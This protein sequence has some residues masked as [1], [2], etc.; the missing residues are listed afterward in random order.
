MTKAAKTDETTTS[1]IRGHCEWLG[2][3]AVKGWALDSGVPDVP[4]TVDLRDTEGFSI[5]LVAEEFRPDLKRAGI[6]TGFHGFA[7]TLPDDFWVGADRKVLWIA[8]YES[9]TLLNGSPLRF[10]YPRFA[11]QVGGPSGGHLRGWCANLSNPDEPVQVQFSESGRVLGYAVADED[12]TGSRGERF[13]AG[14]CG[15][16]FALPGEYLDGSTR[17]LELTDAASGTPLPDSPVLVRFPR[18]RE[19]LREQERYR[20]RVLRAAALH[21]ASPQGNP[22]SSKVACRAASMLASDNPSE[23]NNRRHRVCNVT[24]SESVVVS[25]IVPFRTDSELALQSALSAIATAGAVSTEIILVSAGSSRSRIGALSGVKCVSLKTFCGWPAAWNAG[26]RHACGRIILFLQPGALLEP[27]AL[28]EMVNVFDMRSECAAVAPAIFDA[29]RKLWSSGGQIGRGGEL[30]YE[31]HYSDPDLSRTR[32]LRRTDFCPSPAFAVSREAYAELGGFDES[33]SPDYASAELAAF[34]HH[35]RKEVFVQPSAIVRLE[36]S[37]DFLVHPT[38]AKI[39]DRSGR[40]HLARSDRVHY[41]P[42]P[43]QESVALVIDFQI[44]RW[45]QSAGAKCTANEIS[46]FMA[47]GYRVVLLAPPFRGDAPYR[48]MF[49]REGVECVVARGS[50]AD[51]IANLPE[52]SVVFAIRYYCLNP[53][54]QSIRNRWPN[55]RVLFNPADLHFLREQRKQ[56]LSASNDS[57]VEDIDRITAAELR[58]IEFADVTLPYSSVEVGEIHARIPAARTGIC[59][60]VAEDVSDVPGLKDRAGLVFLG[61]FDHAPN[62]D[63]VQYFVDDI[64]P[65]VLSVLP[66]TRFY[67]FGS[68]MPDEIRDLQSDHVVPMGYVESLRDVYDS[69]RVFV[70]P[71]RFGAGVKGKVIESMSYGCPGVMTDLSIEGIAV[72]PGTHCLVANDPLSFAEQTIELLENDELWMRLHAEVR[73]RVTEV[74]GFSTAVDAF[75]DILTD[76]GLPARRQSMTRRLPMLPIEQILNDQ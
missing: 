5:Q 38:Q 2:G 27:L 41:P 4:V 22:E 17:Y 11:G 61:G 30:T 58:A 68:R 20:E 72:E 60:W 53:Y 67:I 33:L 71:L 44:P 40:R 48:A 70:S 51:V 75:A 52:P 15:F 56:G 7:Y 16:S 57:P 26:A 39:M 10:P 6:G 25:I 3:N 64:L 13:R 34:V 23:T 55:C 65:R 42:L 45:D 19:I 74:Y 32:F 73:K 49:E 31:A 54:A 59:P 8:E 46:M 18:T 62:V 69:A 50:P 29:W 63:A 28:Q 37:A 66:E 24:A 36:R 21:L 9:G 14:R 35:L 12:R 76:A 1:R 43:R 47:L